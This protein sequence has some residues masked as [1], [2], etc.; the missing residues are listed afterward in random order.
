MK[1]REENRESIIQIFAEAAS[2]I[3]EYLEYY[4]ELSREEIAH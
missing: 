4:K 3:L 2:V 1:R